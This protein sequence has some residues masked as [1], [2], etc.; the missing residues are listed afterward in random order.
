M[1]RGPK[2]TIQRGPHVLV[3]GGPRVRSDPNVGACDDED[4]VPAGRGPARHTLGLP[5]FDS[6]TGIRNLATI[7][8]SLAHKE[9]QCHPRLEISTA[10]ASTRYIF[11]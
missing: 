3:Y 9:L 10:V 4:I 7:W 6:P 11:M 5:G 8:H 2:M 1:Q